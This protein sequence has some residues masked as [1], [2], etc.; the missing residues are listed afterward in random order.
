MEGQTL[1]KLIFAT[2]FFLIFP[3]LA[4]A[5]PGRTAADGCHYCR[6]NCDSWGVPWDVRHCH[7]NRI[8]EIL[9]IKV[10]VD[11]EKDRRGEDQKQA[12]GWE[13]S[14]K[15]KRTS[16]STEKQEGGNR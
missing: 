8:E 2:A 11:K 13:Y 3:V 6:T 4:T 15:I 9:P 1:K 10:R 5:H 7:G 14:M 16:I 12:P